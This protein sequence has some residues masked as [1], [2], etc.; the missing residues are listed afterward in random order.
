[1]AAA[2]RR[3]RSW[4][5]PGRRLTFQN[6]DP[7][8][9]R[10]YGVGIK[11]FPVAEQGQGATRDWTVAAPGTFEIRDEAA[12]SLRMWIVA[13][14]N[15]AGITY[16]GMKGDFAVNVETPGEYTLQAYFAGKKVGDPTP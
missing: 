1:M 8:K 15:V 6:T 2:P 9:H 10:L 12:P 4:C 3:S 13:E 11:T 14:P 16:P 5:H 7:F